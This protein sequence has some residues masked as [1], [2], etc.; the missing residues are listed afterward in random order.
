MSKKLE[1]ATL[2][3]G[4]FWC[5]EA[6]YENVKGVEDVVS[7]YAGG[8]TD[9]P[10][11]QD[12]CSG[13]TGHAEVVQ[14][15]YDPDI[16]SYEDLLKIFWTVHDPTTPNRQGA[17]VGTQYRSVIFYHNNDQKSIAEKSRAEVQRH[18]N[19]PIVTEIAPLTKFW[20]A[21]DYH[22]DYFRKNPYHGYCQAVVAPKVDKFRRHFKEMTK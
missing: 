9:H 22:Q 13:T 16:V 3:G 18:F 17:D 19:A 14:I 11:Y 20:P 7:G 12:V 5:L 1:K 2:G 10:S 6:V 21:E 15:T 8:H 4:C